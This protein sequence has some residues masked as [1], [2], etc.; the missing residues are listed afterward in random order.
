MTDI[1]P[2]PV[3]IT[4]LVPTFNRKDELC[5]LFRSLLNQTCRDFEWLVVDDGST[6]G[7]EEAIRSWAR[8]ASFPVRIIQQANQGK[9]VAVNNGFRHAAGLLTMTLDSD[10]MLVPDAIE[11]LK[12]K[13]THYIREDSPGDICGISGL[14]Q[15]E[16]GS[17]VG[18]PYPESEFISDFWTVRNKLRVTGDKK[19]VVLTALAR[20]YPYEVFV[21]EKRMPPSL[22][23]YR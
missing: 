4:V 12:Q 8:D 18:S 5:D 6:D 3:F 22:L 1:A 9:H 7:S 20:Q 21:G 19:E 2:H 15:Y 17:T 16:D 10:D 13:W 23:W 14:F 11:F